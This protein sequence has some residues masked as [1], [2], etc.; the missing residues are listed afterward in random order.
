MGN[1]GV[2][3]RRISI[4]CARCGTPIV[5]KGTGRPG[6]FCSQTCRTRAWEMRQAAAMLDQADPMPT[7][8]RE[9]VERVVERDRPMPAVP[10]TVADWL[11]LL[12]RLRDQIRHDP[13]S[14]VRGRDDWQELAG[15]VLELHESFTWKQPA[16]TPSSG[17]ET[18]AAGQGLSR[19]QR[20][21]LE[22][23]QRKNEGF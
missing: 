13:R 22:R 10:V 2:R 21:A 3:E 5:Y 14:L 7:V 18:A 19:Q 23:Q 8:V 12:D 9:V 6:Q 15:A 4:E 1:D 17:G 20:R 11:P 16:A